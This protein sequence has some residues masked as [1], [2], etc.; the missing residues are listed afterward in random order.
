[1]SPD[2]TGGGPNISLQVIR[3][4]VDYCAPS[5]LVPRQDERV[6]APYDVVSL[7]IVVLRRAFGARAPLR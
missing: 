5:E 3:T 2:R 4:A 1:M 6:V 7:R